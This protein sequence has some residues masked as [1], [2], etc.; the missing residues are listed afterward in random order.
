MNIWTEE[1]SSYT[2]SN[3]TSADIKLAEEHFR[4]KLPKAYTELLKKKNGGKLLYNALPIALDR[5]DDDN[6]LLIEDMFGI[7]EKEGIMETDYFVKEW[8]INRE[9]IILLSGDGHEWIALDYNDST[10]NPKVIY[11]DTENDKIVDLYASFDE[12]LENLYIQEEEVYEDG[13][14]EG[15]AFIITL[16]EARRLVRS[17]DRTDI[18]N[19]LD[20]FDQYK[21]DE[22]ILVEH[23]EN[24]I[25][26]LKHDDEEVAEYAGQMAWS[27]I[28]MGYNVTSEFINSILSDFEKREGQIFKTYLDLITKYLNENEQ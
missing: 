4:V 18:Q 21:Y 6:Y 25:R 17:N 19:G 9:N 16:E 8:E 26:L 24:I 23:Q 15:G 1:E 22:N 7:K 12:M 20:A 5:W 2:L 28:T 10:E 13:D 27:A 14:E 3:L 11:I